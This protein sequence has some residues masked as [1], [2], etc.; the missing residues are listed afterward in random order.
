MTTTKI[1]RGIPKVVTLFSDIR[2][3]IE[4]AD[5]HDLCVHEL[6]SDLDLDEFVDLDEEARGDILKGF[7]LWFVDFAW[8]I[9]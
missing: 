8:L 2:T 3:I 4:E 1:G 7:E 5:H 6:A 9:M